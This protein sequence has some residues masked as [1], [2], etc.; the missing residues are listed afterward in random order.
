[1]PKP[2]PV[3]HIEIAN[4]SDQLIGDNDEIILSDSQLDWL[5]KFFAPIIEE[6]LEGGEPKCLNL[7]K[8]SI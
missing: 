2:E 5:A 7:S 3:I 8:E 6:K 1:M 4:A